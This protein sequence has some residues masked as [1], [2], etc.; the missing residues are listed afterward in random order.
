MPKTNA[1]R[2]RDH[3]QRQ[4]RRHA[5]LETR[6]AEL[7]CRPSTLK[8]NP[9]GTYTVSYTVSCTVTESDGAVSKG[10]A[11]LTATEIT[12][13]VTSLVSSPPSS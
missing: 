1:E 6:C 5:A 3:R 12:Y 11:N 13:E 2:Q 9:G 10:L 8:R 7:A 4:T